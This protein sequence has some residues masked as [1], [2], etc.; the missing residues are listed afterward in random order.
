MGG[1]SHWATTKRHKM[2]Q[3]AKRGRIFTK[4]IREITTAA[5]I[6]GGDVEGNPRLRTAVT[7]AKE[8]NM[9]L[10]NI[11]KAIQ[12]GTGELPGVAY[13]EGIYEG[14]GPGGVAIMIEIMSDNRNRT[15]SEIRYILSKYGGNMGEAGCVSWVFNKRGYIVVEKIHAD[16]E[17]LMGLVLEAGAEDLRTDEKNFEVIT[18]PDDFEKVKK[19]LEN[20]KIP[21]AL[22][23]VT[24]VPQ[25]YVKL[26]GKDAEQMLKLMEAL[27]D[28]DDV[29]K[30]H[31]NFDIPDEVIQRVG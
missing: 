15:V 29:Q 16:E 11:K 23:E 7:K 3:D 21:F 14:Y 31:A 18:S 19:A 26:D 17:K 30:V 8:V 10:D 12:K 20:N 25:N 5:R 24:M 1:H 6:G 13:E 28:H 4:I 27:E 2:A 22:A 9:P